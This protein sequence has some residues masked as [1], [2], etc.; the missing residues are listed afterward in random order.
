MY[1]RLCIP[2][3]DGSYTKVMRKEKATLPAELQLFVV[4]PYITSPA[5]HILS[6]IKDIPFP[7]LLTLFWNENTF[8]H[9]QSNTIP[10]RKKGRCKVRL[11]CRCISLHRYV[12]WCDAWSV[13]WCLICDVMLD[14]WCDAWYVMWCLICDVMLDLWCDESERHSRF[15][16]YTL[17]ITVTIFWSFR[18]WH[19]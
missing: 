13:M 12:M 14:M 5:L 1:G 15:F 19:E 7:S 9:M 4:E 10:R 6:T 17:R 16:L 2:Q 8:L 18:F 11:T 3:A